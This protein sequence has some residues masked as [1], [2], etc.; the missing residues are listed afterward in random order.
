MKTEPLDVAFL[1]INEWAQKNS[2]ISVGEPVPVTEL[3]CRTKSRILSDGRETGTGVYAIPLHGGAL[4]L[5]KWRVSREGKIV[6]FH[7][8]PVLSH[9]PEALVNYF[10]CGARGTR[11]ISHAELLVPKERSMYG[12]PYGKAKKVFKT[13]G[14]D[15]LK[16]GYFLWSGSPAGVVREAE[17]IRGRLEKL[18]TRGGSVFQDVV[19]HSVLMLSNAEPEERERF[20]QEMLHP[21]LLKFAIDKLRRMESQAQKKRNGS[22]SSP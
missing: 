9:S 19:D 7:G 20:G 22:S 1:K 21:V 16:D 10:L 15:P 12:I 3:F 5:S 6:R 8:R 2:Q 13:A 11:F 4:A 14:L 17:Y 18:K